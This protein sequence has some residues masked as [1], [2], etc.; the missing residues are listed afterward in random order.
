MSADFN[1]SKSGGTPATTTPGLA[2]PPDNPTGLINGTDPLGPDYYYGVTVI[3][4][5]LFSPRDTNIVSLRQSTGTSKSTSIDGRSQF[6]LTK[7]WRMRPRL[8]YDTRTRTT[9]TTKT[10]RITI[11]TRFDFRYRRELQFQFEIGADFTTTTDAGITTNDTDYAVDLS[12][13]YDF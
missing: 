2:N 12:Y 4:Q 8:R 1:V 5:N 13:I 11:S 10:D 9:N 7:K 6:S 3:G